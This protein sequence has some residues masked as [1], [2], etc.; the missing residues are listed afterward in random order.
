[1]SMIGCAA[2]LTGPAATLVVRTPTCSTVPQ[3]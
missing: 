3:V 2:A 1:M